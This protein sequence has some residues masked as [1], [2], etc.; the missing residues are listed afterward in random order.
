MAKP[1]NYIMQDQV[2]NQVRSIM[3]WEPKSGHEQARPWMAVAITRTLNRA[4]DALYKGL[5]TAQHA[6][7]TAH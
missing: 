5:H 4:A 1:T 3:A 2:R 7:P 6:T